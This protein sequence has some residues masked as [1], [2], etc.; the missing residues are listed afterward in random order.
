[1]FLLRKL[2]HAL[3]RTV[4][5]YELTVAI[6]GPSDAI[7]RP[8]ID[9]CGLAISRHSVQLGNPLDRDSARMRSLGNRSVPRRTLGAIPHRERLLLQLSVGRCKTGAVC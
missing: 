7:A 5:Q 3:A 6:P 2:Q 8:G 9:V 4:R 1:M